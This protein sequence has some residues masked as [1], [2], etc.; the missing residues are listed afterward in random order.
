MEASLLMSC[1]DVPDDDGLGVILSVNQGAKGHQVSIREGTLSTS[2]LCDLL[3]Q[4][5]DMQSRLALNL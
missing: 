2:L 3:R 5:T 4:Y 1:K